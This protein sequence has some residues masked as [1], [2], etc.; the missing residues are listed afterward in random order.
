MG[1]VKHVIRTPVPVG[2]PSLPAPRAPFMALEHE[3]SGPLGTSTCKGDL[4]NVCSF[5][6]TSI[7]VGVLL[8]FHR[9]VKGGWQDRKTAKMLSTSRM[10]K[11][12]LCTDFRAY[13]LSMVNIG[14]RHNALRNVQ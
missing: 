9:C 5:N 6:P 2:L 14:R 12:T 3:G 1:L 13:L 7:I 10:L 11:N 8:R 4:N